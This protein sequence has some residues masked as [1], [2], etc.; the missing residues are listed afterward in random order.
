MAQAYIALIGYY[1]LNNQHQEALL[2]V[3]KLLIKLPNSIRAIKARADILSSLGYHDQALLDWTSALEYDE[4]FDSYYGRGLCYYHKKLFRSA[5][6]D[7]KKANTFGAEARGFNAMGKCLKEFGDDLK[8]IEIQKKAIALDPLYKEAYL[9]IA[10]A[11]MSQSMASEAQEYLDRVFA[12]DPHMMTAHGWAALF[13]DQLGESRKVLE[14]V[15]K[16]LSYDPTQL[17]T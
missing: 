10:I 13:Y 5:Y 8:A 7:F 12:L 9:D 14:S 6:K 11:F 16:T 15:Q 3:S 4:D 17:S 2:I 1:N